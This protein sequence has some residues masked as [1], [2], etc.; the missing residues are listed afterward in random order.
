MWV[1]SPAECSD[2]S[3][4]NPISAPNRTATTSRIMIVGSGQNVSAMP[5]ARRMSVIGRD[6]SP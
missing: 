6:L 3:R 4:S 2:H 5:R 1:L